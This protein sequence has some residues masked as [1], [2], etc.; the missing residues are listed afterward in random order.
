MKC[1][2]LY[3][4]EKLVLRRVNEIPSEGHTAQ[5]R[6]HKNRPVSV[7]PDQPQQPCL[8]GT[9]FFQAP[10]EVAKFFAAPSCDCMENIAY[11]GKASFDSSEARVHAARNNATKS[12]YQFHFR[13][14]CDDA[15]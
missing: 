4:G 15:R 3:C 9:I 6:I 11:C 7:I 10:G 5:V 12:G 8:T 1:R 14:H 13:R 2:S